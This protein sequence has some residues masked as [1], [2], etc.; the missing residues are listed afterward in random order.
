MPVFWLSDEFVM[1]IYWMV[2]GRG[3]RLPI[4]YVTLYRIGPNAVWE[5]YGFTTFTERWQ[6]YLRPT[7]E[8]NPPV[9][10]VMLRRPDGTVDD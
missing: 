5:G 8:G 10:I 3:Q 7:G 9:D 1:T 4:I 6:F 2:G